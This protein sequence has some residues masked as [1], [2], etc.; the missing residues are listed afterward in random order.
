VELAQLP[1]RQPTHE[2]AQIRSNSGSAYADAAVRGEANEVALSPTGQRN[3][4]LN[5]AAYRLGQLV[6]ASLLT[7]GAVTDSLVSAA[8]SAGLSQREAR[9]TIRSGLL[10]GLSHP[11][12]VELG[13]RNVEPPR[14]DS[15]PREWDDLERVEQEAEPC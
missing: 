4:R 9:A 11:R 15:R 3:S 1:A 12:G 13:N 8:T 10:A 2:V 5:L 14:S 7:E 6:G